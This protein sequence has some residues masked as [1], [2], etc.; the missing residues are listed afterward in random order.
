MENLFMTVLDNKYEE[1]AMFLLQPQD[2][3][4]QE[5]DADEMP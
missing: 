1:A 3:R 4:P 2:F 5:E